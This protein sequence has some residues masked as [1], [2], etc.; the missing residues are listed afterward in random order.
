ML[1]S[2]DINLVINLAYIAA[3]ILF[4]FGLK[5]LSSPATAR[6]GNLMSS[7]GMLIAIVV[8]L[9]NEVKL[10]WE[11]IIAGLIIGGLIGAI[12]ARRV[13]MTG[14]PELVALFNGFGGASSLLVGLVAVFA[15]T[16]TTFTNITIILSILIGGV[17][18][19]GSLIAYG[20][21][22]ERIPSKAIQFSGQQ[23]FNILLVIAIIASAVMFCMQPSVD[24][25]WLYA[26][27]G[28]SLLF[29]IMITIP[30][31]GADMPVV[32]ALL[33]SYSGLAACAAGFVLGNNL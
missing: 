5:K 3:A 15:T 17:T 22:S 19:T 10:P 20:K 14:M 28:L 26:V 11:N 18:L 29:G 16:N 27:I 33:N 23:I 1:E 30:I 4:V 21:L 8:T 31:G 32:I 2:L 12:S 7:V 6:K 24:S 9:L 13:Q 25:Q